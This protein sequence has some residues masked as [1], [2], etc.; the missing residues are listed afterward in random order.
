[1]QNAHLRCDAGFHRGEYINVSGRR[2]SERH[3]RVLDI[4]EEIS[5]HCVKE[6]G[7]GDMAT[8]NDKR[9]RWLMSGL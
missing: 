2:E 9:E 3:K 6:N 7:A 5:N 4:A 8:F 1:M